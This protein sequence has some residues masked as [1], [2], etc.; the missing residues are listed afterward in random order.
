MR[1]TIKYSMAVEEGMRRFFFP[2]VSSL[3]LRQPPRD[4]EPGGLAAERAQRR[5]RRAR[6]QPSP[7]RPRPRPAPNARLPP[8][9]CAPRPR[10]VPLAHRPTRWRRGART[11]PAARAR[12][13]DG[14][15]LRGS[16]TC[17]PALREVA[18]R[19]RPPHRPAVLRPRRRSRP[20][21]RRPPRFG[22][23]RRPPRS[24]PAAGP[25]CLRSGHPSCR[26]APLQRCGGAVRGVPPARGCPSC[27]SGSAG[28]RAGLPSRR[29]TSGLRAGHRS[30][31]CSG[32]GVGRGSPAACRAP[33][34]CAARSV[35]VPRTARGCSYA[36]PVVSEQCCSLSFRSV[37]HACSWGGNDRYQQSHPLLRSVSCPLPCVTASPVLPA[38]GLVLPVTKFLPG[39]G[40]GKEAS[41]SEGVTQWGCAP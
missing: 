14:R 28:G 3:C 21:P 11:Q 39:G 25:R 12:C 38:A 1:V 22:A 20:L 7:A 23:A 16:A 19:R 41:V 36:P 29:R 30:C 33:G 5:R 8:P 26:P 4:P 32:A 34:V 15:V 13:G 6:T 17:S 31:R 2:L 9:P 27:R 35:S 40:G 24:A 37:F 18:A 10:Q